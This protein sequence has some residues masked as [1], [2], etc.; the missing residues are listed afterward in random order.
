MLL[1]GVCRELIGAII[2]PAVSIAAMNI[3]LHE[4]ARRS[5]ED[6]EDRQSA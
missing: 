4:G 1:D 5:R 6:C 2:A 3:M